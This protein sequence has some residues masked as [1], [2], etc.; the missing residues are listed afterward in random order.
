MKWSNKK[1][2]NFF[3][4]L[5]N[6]GKKWNEIQI[7]SN[8]EIEMSWDWML[9]YSKANNS[10]SLFHTIKKD[11]KKINKK[12]LTNMCSEL[13]NQTHTHTNGNKVSNLNLINNN[14]FVFLCFLVLFVVDVF[15]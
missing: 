3:S 2:R 13:H 12:K 7:N 6:S 10:L 9:I 4:Y 15:V 1:E 5:K 14:S 8:K 11:T